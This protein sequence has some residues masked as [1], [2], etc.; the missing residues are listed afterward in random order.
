[1]SDTGFSIACEADIAQLKSLKIPFNYRNSIEAELLKDEKSNHFRWV[2]YKEN[3]VILAFHR[4]IIISNWGFFSGV[5][6]KE[7]IPDCWM[8]HKIVD[9]AIEDL[10]SMGCSGC[11]AWDDS[12]KTV[13][14]D[15]L[16]RSGF[17]ISPLLIYRLIFNETGIKHINSY[18]SKEKNLW[19]DGRDIDAEEIN[20][21]HLR[22]SSFLPDVQDGYRNRSNWFVKEKDGEV[23]AAINWWLHQNLLEIHYT[24][25][26]EP[27]MDITEGI[28]NLVKKVSNMNHVGQFKI[29]LESQ[30]KLS[31]IRLSA[32][33]P[34]TYRGGYENLCLIKEF[35]HNKGDRGIIEDEKI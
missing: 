14:T 31:F 9:Y 15:M 7:N 35:Q 3:D 13:K 33:Q 21:L 29:N 34:H 20:N 5:F 6:V 4:S 23:M 24:L 25:S 19:R 8:V 1:M 17:S 10:K 2:V 32:F 30:R 16:S 18:L 22:G 27:Y 28:I 26:K 12:P 11:I